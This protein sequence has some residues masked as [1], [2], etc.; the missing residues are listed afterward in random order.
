MFTRLAEQNE[1]LTK[2]QK[3]AQLLL[4]AINKANGA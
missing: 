4:D 1:V 2:Y 3:R